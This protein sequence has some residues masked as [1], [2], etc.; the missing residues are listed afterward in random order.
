MRIISGQFGGRLLRSPEGM[1]TRPITDRVKLALFNIL[2]GRVEGAVVLDLFCGTGSMGLEC[3]S[4]GAT[5]CYFADRDA[6]ALGG[7]RENIAA[8]G[9]ADRC[10]I[11]PGDIL[12]GPPVRLAEVAGEVQLAFVDPP[13][14]LVEEWDWP[15][16]TAVLF[17]P[18]A[19]K[20]SAEGVVVLRCERSTA[21]PDA[22]GPLC[23]RQRRDYGKMSLVFLHG[24]AEREK[25][26]SNDPG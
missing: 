23:V 12:A 4:R 10:R 25:P 15:Q 20:L 5:F 24:A 26:G 2:G 6:G 13:Y 11:W 3:L 21:V 1:T 18:L 14:R 22:I 16:A 8:L 9:V 7:L 19:G 17:A